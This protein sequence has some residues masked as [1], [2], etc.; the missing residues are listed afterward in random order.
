MRQNSELSNRV[1]QFKSNVIA[2]QEKQMKTHN[3]L[4]LGEWVLQTA[5]CTV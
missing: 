2:S 4:C 5:L 1:L 3:S